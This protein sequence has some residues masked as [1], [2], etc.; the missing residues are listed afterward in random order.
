MKIT[1]SSK[2]AFLRV[3]LRFK[4]ASVFRKWKMVILLGGS[5]QL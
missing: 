3:S 5:P 4:S 1:E 2:C